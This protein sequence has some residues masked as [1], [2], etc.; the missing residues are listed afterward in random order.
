[1]KNS[2]SARQ[3]VNIELKT[4]NHNQRV[5]KILQNHTPEEVQS[6][7]KIDFYCE[8]SDDSCTKRVPM[9]FKEYDDLHNSPA[10]FVL[11]KGHQSPMVEEVVKTD[12]GHLVVDKYA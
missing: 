12:S 1:M 5:K 4:R 10:R 2:S 11:V 6:D 8:C 9:T 7:L 3:Q